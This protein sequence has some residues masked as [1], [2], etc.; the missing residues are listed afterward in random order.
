MFE[1]SQQTTKDFKQ[2]QW[3]YNFWVSID[4]YLECLAKSKKNMTLN[5]IYLNDNKTTLWLAK[6]WNLLP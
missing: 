6:F 4:E 3:L 1:S 2:N 5:K